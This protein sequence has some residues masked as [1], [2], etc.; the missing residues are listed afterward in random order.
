MKKNLT[1][2]LIIFSVLLYSFTQ[3]N[4]VVNALKKGSASQ[5]S[6]YFDKTVNISLPTKGN[7]Y[8]KSQAELVLKDFFDN[9][10]VKSFE[11]VQQK[12][13]YQLQYIVGTL[14][15]NSGEFKTTLYIKQKQDKQF[16]QEIKFEK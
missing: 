6:K 3:V 9:N 5:L 1:Y 15:T 10:G 11:I 12:N 16:L 13:T 14:L 4:D 8:S 7:T 2:C